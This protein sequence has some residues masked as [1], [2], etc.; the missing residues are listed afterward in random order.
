MRL[1]SDSG[2][3]VVETTLLLPFILL[4]IMMLVEFGFAFYTHVTVN[5]A[6]SEAARY[7]A[8]ANLPSPTCDPDSI[9]ERAVDFAGGRL[10][11]SEVDVTYQYQAGGSGDFSRGDG[12]TVRITHMYDPITPMPGL[13]SLF[14][15]NVLPATWTMSACSDS[16]LEAKPTDQ[17]LLTADPTDCGG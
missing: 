1:K 10:L 9:E 12:V 13:F 15:G 8:V 5:N 17:G 14:T 7:A 2:Q 4:L 6:A 11:C 16:R 3:T